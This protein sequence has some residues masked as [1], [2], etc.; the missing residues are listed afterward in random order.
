LTSPSLV[1]SQV[2]SPANQQNMNSGK[3]DRTPPPH[4]QF[5]GRLVPC[6]AIQSR[7]SYI[8]HQIPGYYQASLFANLAISLGPSSGSSWSALSKVTLFTNHSRGAE[9]CAIPSRRNAA[10]IGPFKFLFSDSPWT[11]LLRWSRNYPPQ[12]LYLRRLPFCS[13]IMDSKPLSDK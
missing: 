3:N 2:Y 8:S 6:G 12:V 5:G 10:H 9:R 11:H 4:G 13:A 1:V 7:E